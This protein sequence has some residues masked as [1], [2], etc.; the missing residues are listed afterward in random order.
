MPVPVAPTTLVDAVRW[1]RT[2]VPDAV[3]GHPH[4]ADDCPLAGALSERAVRRRHS[5]AALGM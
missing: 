3:C 5:M 2:L 4:S 1:L